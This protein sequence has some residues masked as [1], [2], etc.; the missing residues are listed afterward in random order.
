MSGTNRRLGGARAC[1]AAGGR[2]SGHHH[3]VSRRHAHRGGCRGGR[4]LHRG[5]DRQVHR[6]P[7][8][9]CGRR[10]SSPRAPTGSIQA[11]AE[12]ALGVKLGR[13]DAD[14]VRQ[15]T[16]FAIG[17]VA[18]VGHVSAAAAAAGRGP[19]G[20]RSGLGGR[21][22]AEPRVSDIGE[23]VAADHRC[24]GRPAYGWHRNPPPPFPAL[25]TGLPRAIDDQLA[26]IAATN[27]ANARARWL[28][29][30]F[31]AESI[32]PNVTEHPFGTNIGS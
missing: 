30:C 29:A 18:P 15:T 1:G 21:R 32:S 8:R 2:P 19:A 28:M 7:L 6:V 10:W 9:R 26:A 4:R 3:P 14:W 16:G 24:K 12:A 27:C 17:G 11:K 13:A 23:G 22:L 5:A 25:A 20:A 31:S